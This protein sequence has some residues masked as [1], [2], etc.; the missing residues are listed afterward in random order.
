VRRQTPRYIQADL[1]IEFICTDAPYARVR[2]GPGP[3]QAGLPAAA[4]R[5]QHC[6]P[7]LSAHGRL[8]RVA[9]AEVLCPLMT[10]ALTGVALA[11]SCGAGCTRCCALR[12]RSA[13]TRVQ[14]YSAR[15]CAHHAGWT[16][17]CACQGGW[18]PSRRARASCTRPCRPRRRGRACAWTRGACTARTRPPCPTSRAWRRCC[19]RPPA[20]PPCARRSSQTR[21]HECCRSVH[22]W[23][24]TASAPFPPSRPAWL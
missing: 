19:S 14:V 13:L 15:R 16:Q 9:A 3:A 2:S 8:S 21:L 24:L 22:H 7:Q 20:L 1:C 18:T 4:R 12:P 11:D 10:V 5:G 17:Q 6:Q 23:A